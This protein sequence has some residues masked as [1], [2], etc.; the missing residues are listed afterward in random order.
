M[1]VLQTTKQWDDIA[2]SPDF[3]AQLADDRKRMAALLVVGH[4]LLDGEDEGHA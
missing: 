4:H 3:K 1:A 2:A